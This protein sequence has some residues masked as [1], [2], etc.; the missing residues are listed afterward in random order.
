MRFVCK[1][2]DTIYEDENWNFGDNTICPKCNTEWEVE[3][4]YTDE[5]DNIGAWLTEKISKQR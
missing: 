2:C 3:W 4:D 5:E 1:E